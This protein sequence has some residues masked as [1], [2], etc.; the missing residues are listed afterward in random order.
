MSVHAPVVVLQQTEAPGQGLGLHAEP[1]IATLPFAQ[2]GVGKV[3]LKQ[4]CPTSPPE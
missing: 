4:V 3:A 1:G 2:L